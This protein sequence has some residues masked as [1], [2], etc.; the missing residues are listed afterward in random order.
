M[1]SK[2]FTGL[3]KQ[4]LP[5]SNS[6]ILQGESGSCTYITNK[7]KNIIARINMEGIGNPVFES[8]GVGS[9]NKFTSLISTF[10]KDGEIDYSMNNDGVLHLKTPNYNFDYYVYNQNYLQD[11]QL[12][13]AFLQQLL[14]VPKMMTFELSQNVI[15]NIKDVSGIFELKHVVFSKHPEEGYV[16]VSVTEIKK[17]SSEGNMK[18]HTLDIKI[19]GAIFD[20]EEEFV[21][22][23][24]KLNKLISDDYKGVVYY[25][26]G[27]VSSLNMIPNSFNGLDYFLARTSI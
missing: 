5:I 8:F 23:I 10:E 25:V 2:K 16:N 24:E 18:R 20:A 27:K 26:K 9:L 1:L 15:K 12:N 6:A 19:P 7:S 11:Y 14:S 22:D 4:L 3:L 21:L 13:P 17:Y